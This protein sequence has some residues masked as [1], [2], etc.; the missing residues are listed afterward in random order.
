M[1]EVVSNVAQMR[2][3]ILGFQEKLAELPQVEIPLTHHFSKDIYGREIL[4]PA[5]TVVIG[6]IHKHSSLNILAGGEISLLT[7][8]GTK[9]IKAPYTV[10]SKPGIKRV[11]YVHKDAT[12]VTVH[13]TDEKDVDKIEDQFIA[14]TYDDV[15]KL[16]ELELKQ[17]DELK[18]SDLCLGY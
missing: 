2:E 6:K 12:W 11:I 16:N 1:S 17:I 15:A 4:M 13:G 8:E 14:K 10:V 5:G 9:R 3:S 18:R 7:E